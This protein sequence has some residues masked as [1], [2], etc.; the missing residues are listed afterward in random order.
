MVNW[1]ELGRVAERWIAPPECLV[2]QRPVDAP[3]APLVCPVCA[4]RWRP[5]EHP[6][7]DRCG[8][9]SPLGLACRLCGDWPPEL[10]AV[11]SAVRLDATLRPLMH[12][13]KYH[14]WWRLAEEFAPRMAVLIR[15]WPAADLVPIPLSPRRRRRRGYNQ[16][17]VLARA[18]SR[19]TGRPIRTERLVRVRHTGSQ[20]LLAPEARRA[21]LAAAFAGRAD[22][23][24]AILVDDVFT[25]GATLC[26][27][28]E[29]L[30]AAGV[31]EVRGVTF[32]RAEL[33]LANASPPDITSTNRLH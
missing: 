26:S 32:A 17:E 19:H 10:A 22:A 12:Q 7:C 24:A 4:S 15:D 6:Q 28:A 25:T 33:P 5:I 13:F 14:G 1:R 2:C 16:A 27:A 18:L 3:G 21:N 29:A 30:V 31:A 11:R 23:A 20:T 9:P 8:E